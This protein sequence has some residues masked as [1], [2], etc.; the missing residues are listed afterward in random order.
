ML[1]ARRPLVCVHCPN[2]D[3]VRVPA[4]AVTLRHCTDDGSWEYWLVCSECGERSAGPSNAWLALE[5]FAAGSGLV[6]W[7]LPDE[8]H[9]SRHG[10][11]LNLVDLAELRLALA[12]PD[13]IASLEASS[14]PRRGESPSS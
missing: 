7:R 11:P 2:C 5:A 1:N 14:R 10:P 3:M 6:E 4:A 13:W 8:L 9:E 12:D